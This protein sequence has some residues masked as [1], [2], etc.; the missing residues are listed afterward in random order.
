MQN[1]SSLELVNFLLEE[2]PEACKEIQDPANDHAGP[3]AKPNYQWTPLHLA[4]MSG[5]EVAI[6]K[7]LLETYPE[8]AKKADTLEQSLPLHLCIK[9]DTDEAVLAALLEAHPDGAS[10]FAGNAELPL[11]KAIAIATPSV[12]KT[13]LKAFPRGVKQRTFPLD[14]WTPLE[15][16][17]ERLKDGKVGTPAENQEIIDAIEATKKTV[18]ADFKQMVA[19][20]PSKP[21]VQP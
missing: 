8:A 17:K 10:T 19:S 3:T 21:K 16:A 7:R 15:Q 12:V 18:D 11:H 13:L 1:K 14:R 5:V 9:A 2:W 20:M 4:C 6:V